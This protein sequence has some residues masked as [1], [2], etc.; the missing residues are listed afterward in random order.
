ML[1]NRRSS[2]SS[3]S[4][5]RSVITTVVGTVFCLLCILYWHQ[6][7]KSFSVVDMVKLSPLAPLGANSTTTAPTTTMAT[8]IITVASHTSAAPA[9]GQ[10][11]ITIGSQGYLNSGP[12]SHNMDIGALVRNNSDVSTR[13]NRCF[14]Y[15]IS[16]GCKCF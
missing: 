12:S 15:L 3:Y 14:C 5:R 10:P 2:A 4:G 6:R 8:G 13:K 1:I 16:C 9:D 7:Q 11:L